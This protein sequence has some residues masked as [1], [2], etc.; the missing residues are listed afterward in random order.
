MRPQIGQLLVFAS[1]SLGAGVGGGSGMRCGQRGD[2]VL[3]KGGRSLALRSPAYPSERAVCPPATGSRVDGGRRRAEGG[4]GVHETLG[5][6]ATTA[7]ATAGRPQHPWR[8]PGRR[9]NGGRGET[10][11]GG[12]LREWRGDGGVGGGG[13][14]WLSH[15]KR[16]LSELRGL[17]NINSG[18]C[19]HSE[20]TYSL[21]EATQDASERIDEKSERRKTGEG[22]GGR[23]E[24]RSFLG[25]G[26]GLLY[27]TEEADIVQVWTRNSNPSVVYGP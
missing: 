24:R 13:L 3:G 12:L 26:R 5:G 25:K 16:H 14:A 18:T 8:G 15:M 7:M 17:D 20:T 21:G 6:G 10:K 11:N 4:R 1:W 23:E 22:G 9:T 27:C 19:I 2:G